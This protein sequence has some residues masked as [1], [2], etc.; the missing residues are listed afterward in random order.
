MTDLERRL[1]ALEDRVTELQRELA[2]RHGSMAQTHRC[3]A[4]GGRRLLHFKRVHEQAESS[5]VDMALLMEK[6]WLTID[7]FGHLETYACASCGLVE[8][9]AQGLDEVPA[10]DRVE[11]LES[12]DDP[13]VD[14]QGPFR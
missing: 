1:A 3:P 8:W 9:H 6:H 12:V 2:R 14:P 7:K 13:P 4:C 11:R 5:A 10:S